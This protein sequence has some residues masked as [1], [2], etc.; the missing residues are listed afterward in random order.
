VFRTVVVTTLDQVFNGGEQ[1]LKL[2]TPN[3]NNV[4]KIDIPK[5]IQDGNQVRYENVIDGASLM[6]EF[7]VTPHL[8]YERRL[9][10]LYCNQQV[11]VL[12]LIVGTT[13]EF[14][15]LGGKT[16]EVTV[17]PKTQPFMQLKLG[18]HGMPIQG[19]HAYGDQI[20][21]L[22]PFIPDIIDERITNSILQSKAK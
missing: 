7:R 2:Q 11:S 13:F 9:N 18:G 6:V 22:K 3:G 8:K 21:L 1:V 19:T 10:D 5:G 15:T 12:D 17:P 20:I 14:T 16:L 4:V